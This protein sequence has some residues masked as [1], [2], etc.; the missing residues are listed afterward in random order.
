MSNPGISQLRPVRT[1]NDGL[2]V[3]VPIASGET[4]LVDREVF[5]RLVAQGVSPNWSRT[6]DRG[7]RV[8]VN[9]WDR[10]FKNIVPVVRLI[11]D[12]KK[13][14][15]VSYR[16]GDRFDLRRANLV[17]GKGKA[18]RDTSSAANG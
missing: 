7:G 14:A 17:L 8:Y 13:R 6:V 4:A 9:V 10:R 2:T 3:F 15:V 1:S 16:N 18:K 11:T 12:A 5:E